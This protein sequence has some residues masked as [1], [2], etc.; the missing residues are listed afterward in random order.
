MHI[1]SPLP[2][3]IEFENPR[4]LSLDYANPL[5]PVQTESQK[6]V[7]AQPYFQNEE[8]STSPHSTIPHTNNS[9][10]QS[11]P[12]QGRISIANAVGLARQFQPAVIPGL[13]AEG[14]DPDGE[15]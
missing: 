15:F 9:R 11:W 4:V 5:L 10:P 1:T 7:P 8:T 2:E 14:P 12:L 13:L 6:Y 3:Q